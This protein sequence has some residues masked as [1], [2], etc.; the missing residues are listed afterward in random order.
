[1]KI[2][3]LIFTCLAI[4]ISTLANAAYIDALHPSNGSEVRSSFQYVGRVVD[5]PPSRPTSVLLSIRDKETGDELVVDQFII[6]DPKFREMIIERVDLPPSQKG[7]FVTITLTARDI[8]TG[9]EL[10]TGT[11]EALV[12]TK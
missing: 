5:L 10:T 4:S 6:E 11:I 2:V 3:N 12:K 7:R 9:D 1:M 8:E